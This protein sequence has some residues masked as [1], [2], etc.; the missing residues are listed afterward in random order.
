MCGLNGLFA[1]VIL[2]I[3]LHV[4]CQQLRVRFAL[5]EKW[6]SLLRAIFSKY[7]SS[8]TYKLIMRKELL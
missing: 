5:S 4:A 3:W 7:V 1:V 6:K 2:S 8:Q